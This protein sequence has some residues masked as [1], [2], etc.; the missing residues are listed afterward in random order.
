MSHSGELE[1]NLSLVHCCRCADVGQGRVSQTLFSVF[2]GRL[3]IT[4]TRQEATENKIS[5]LHSKFYPKNVFSM[6]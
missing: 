3:D 5:G 6:L 4:L 2:T 1:R